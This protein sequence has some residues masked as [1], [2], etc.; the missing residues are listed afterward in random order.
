MEDR[1]SAS[2]TMSEHLPEDSG[3]RSLWS[4][5]AIANPVESRLRESLDADV[6]VVGG[7]YTGLS[8]ALH[9]AE[10]GLSVILLEARSIGFGGSGRNAG[11]VNAGVWRNPEHVVEVLGEEAGQ[12]FNLALRDSP[13]LVFELV[14]RFGMDCG[15]QRC[16]TVNIAHSSTGMQRLETRCSQL[17]ALGAGVELIDGAAAGQISGSPVYRHGGILD[18]AAGTIQPLSY[19]R[20]L[21]LAAQQLG[22]GLYQESGL[23][24][25]RRQGGRWQART[26]SGSVVAEQVIIATNA[27]TEGGGQGVSESILPVSIF[28]CATEPMDEALAAEI[29]PQRHGL[30]DTQAL[31]TSARVDSGRRLVMSSAGDLHGAQGSV[32]EDWMARNRNRLFP[33]ARG[34][35]WQYRWSGC[36][37]VTSSKI[38]R[39]QEPA[40]GIFAP[41]GFNGRGIGTGTVVG[42]HLAELVASGDRKAFPFPLEALYREQWRAPR[43]GYYQYGTLALQFV[44]RRGG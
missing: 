16:G 3:E 30:W 39:I 37:G 44:D 20:S 4:A 42:K 22:V 34:L 26:D 28:Q 12:R 41:A 17:Q 24:E 31:M 14:E 36:V 25:L 9:L 18:P 21:A 40:P 19:V 1:Q 7:G 29:I 23:G 43:A 2:T 15:A 13:T 6:L 5:T 32:R 8:S 11:L 10:Q 38:L 33:Q 35:R 27:Y